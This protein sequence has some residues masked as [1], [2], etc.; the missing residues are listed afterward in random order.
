MSY[1]P[2][3]FGTNRTVPSVPPITSGSTCPD[4]AGAMT[5]S[6]TERS[7][8]SS[9]R[10]VTA[11]MSPALSTTVELCDGA[12]GVSSWNEVSLQ[13][14]TSAAARGATTSSS[15]HIHFMRGDT[16]DGAPASAPARLPVYLLS[17]TAT[18]TV[19]VVAPQPTGLVYTRP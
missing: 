1:E 11:T 8:D 14:T 19:A 3:T 15:A 17:G 10:I 18:V 7:V 12:A 16:E 5:R 4:S 6:V 13:R 9:G 2:L